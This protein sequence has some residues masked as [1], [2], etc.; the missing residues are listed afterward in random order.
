MPAKKGKSQNYQVFNGVRFYKVK[1]GYYKGSGG[2]WMHRYVWSFYNGPVPDGCDVHHKDGNRGNNAIENLECVMRRS[3]HEDHM[4]LRDPSELRDIA[5]NKMIPAAAEW[6][7]S[8]EGRLW[9]KKHYASTLGEK[10]NQMITKTCEYCG[11]EYQVSSLL[12][13]KSRFCS[14]NCK[15]QSRRVSGADNEDRTCVICGKHFVAGK[16]TKTKT[17]SRECSVE[18]TK[19]S[20]LA[21]RR[22]PASDL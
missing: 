12:D 4:S 17:C 15:T 5:V 9:H 6:H 20:K 22:P 3:H 16:Y 7:K 8:A 2:C 14:N 11:K 19:R 18:S 13:C 21:K 10:R 1:S